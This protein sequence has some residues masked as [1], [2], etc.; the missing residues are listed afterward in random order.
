MGYRIHRAVV[1]PSIVQESTNSIDK[2]AAVECAVEEG[3]G[4][5]LGRQEIGTFAE[6]EANGWQ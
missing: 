5:A 2:E 3:L 6:E 1:A 4:S